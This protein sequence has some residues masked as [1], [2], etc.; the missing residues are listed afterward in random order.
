MTRL[1]LIPPE[2]LT[3]GAYAPLTTPDSRGRRASGVPIFTLAR[4][5]PLLFAAALLS[6]CVTINIY[7]PAAAAEKAADRII[8][9]IYKDD[10]AKPAAPSPAPAAAPV[11]K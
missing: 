4:C 7:F 11:Q 2:I 6:A 1:K 5:F 3:K 8:D 9:D 10:G